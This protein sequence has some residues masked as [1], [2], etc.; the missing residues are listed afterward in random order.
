MSD[1]LSCAET[2]K[3]VRAALKKNFPGVKFSV[4][5][6]NY[7]GGASIDVRWLDG[8]YKGAVEKVAKSFTGG[9]FDGMIDMKYNTTAW[10]LPDGSAILADNPGT[11]GSMG[12]VPAQK[13]EKPSPDA[14]LVNF[15]ADFIFCYR[16]VSRPIYEATVKKLCAEYDIAEPVIQGGDK[17]NWVDGTIYVPRADQYLGTLVHRELC[18]EPAN[19]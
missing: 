19:A 10:L 11:V 2:A 3:L 8:P 7:A 18:K 14:K 17:D 12:T 4:R 13:N 9:G 1:Y 6:D 16:D 15:G 5:S